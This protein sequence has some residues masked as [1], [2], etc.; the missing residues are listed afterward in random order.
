MALKNRIFDLINF[1]KLRQEQT[2]NLIA[3]ENYSSNDVMMATGSVLTNKYAEG[4]PGR[5]Y[6][7]GCECVDLVE[8]IAIDL[9]KKIF[10]AD[11]ANVQPHSGSSANMSVYSSQLNPGDTI[12]GMDINSG[13]HLTHGHKVN[14]SGKIYNFI[15]YGVCKESE[16]IDYDQIERLAGQHKPKMIVVGASA[17]SR[18]IDFERVGQIAKKYN[19]LM[20]SDI[21][22]IAGLVAT[23]LHPSPLPFSDFVTSTTHKTLRGPRG[24]LILCKSSY[25]K[26]LDRSVMPGNQ[27]GPLMH[28]IAAKAVAFAQALSSEFE[29]Y[30][31]QVVRNAK[32]MSKAFQNLGYRIVAGG[33]D[34]HLFLM[35][36]RFNNR[37]V[38]QRI[39]GAA[40]EEA[41]ER[42][43]INVNKNLIPFDAQGPMITSGIRL[44]TPA[45][46]TRGFKEKEVE[47]VAEWIDEAMRH[48]DD[49]IY[50]ERLKQKVENLCRRF[51]IYEKIEDK[52]KVHKHCVTS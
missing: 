30:Q 5:R 9:C 12:L 28:V 42:I 20:L 41:L 32:A 3:S 50:L 33:T 34:N 16:L 27:G 36:L 22:H 38:G 11:Y 10:G 14:F 25:S 35:D 48:K 39:T 4:Y 13:G 26:N 49:Q 40:A 8:N 43:S 7:S 31:K 51:P 37:I 45:V 29:E 17:Y 23:N 19:S 24:G 47:L 6:Y 21:A 2:I 52:L 18:T 1:E 44:G 15:P 46:T